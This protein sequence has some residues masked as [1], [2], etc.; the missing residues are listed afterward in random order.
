MLTVNSDG[1]L[2]IISERPPAD[3]GM[4]LPADEV[5]RITSLLVDACPFEQDLGKGTCADC[6]MHE[7][8]ITMDGQ[9]YSVQVTDV[10]VTA[11]LKA[12][13]DVLGEYLQNTD[14]KST[15]I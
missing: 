3:M 4:T 8:E 9:S 1:E 14:S 5:A 6:F 12:L 15:I 2:V 10:T 7:L 13:L 11:E